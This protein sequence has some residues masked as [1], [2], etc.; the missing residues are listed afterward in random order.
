MPPHTPPSHSQAPRA[1][2]SEAAPSLAPRP[3]SGTRASSYSSL[4]Q[5]LVPPSQARDSAGDRHRL[6]PLHQPP[7]MSSD[8][9]YMYQ[10]SPEVP[11]QYPYPPYSPYDAAQYPPSSSRPA[12]NS[13]NPPPPNAPH[14]P[15]PP[16]YPP[17]PPPGYPQQPYAPTPPYGVPP[18]HQNPP[19]WTPE[20]WAQY[21]Q[22]FVPSNQPPVQEPQSFA[23]P[24]AQPQ[25]PGDAAPAPAAPSAPVAAS[26]P[27]NPDN[28]RAEDR[29]TEPAPPPPRAR[30]GKG[31]EHPAPTP[32]PPAHVQ[33]LD[34]DKVSAHLLV[35]CAF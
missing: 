18:P 7:A 9:R 21:P 1:P 24:E 32:L 12:R 11:A 2:Y 30:K 33:G 28:R 26:G 13:A 10:G 4:E 3:S 29:A 22:P 25:A 19:Q 20:G 17:Q 16:A 6:P 31:N 27:A 15:Q 14:Q 34:Y 8:A 23:R 35:V 5:A